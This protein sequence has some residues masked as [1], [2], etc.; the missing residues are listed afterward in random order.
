MPRCR[1]NSRDIRLSFLVDRVTNRTKCNIDRCPQE[2]R[3]IKVKTSTLKRH[4]LSKHAAKA[5]QLDLLPDNENNENGESDENSCEVKRFR[6]QVNPNRIKNAALKLVTVHGLPLSLF[7]YEGF[8]ELTEELFSKINFKI[9][10]RNCHNLLALAAHQIR[11]KIVLE[12][13]NKM[14]SLKI[15]ITTRHGKHILGIILQFHS[16]EKIVSRNIG[17]IELFVRH[18]GKNISA[19]IVK[20]LDSFGCS[21]NQIY[22]IAIDN[23]RN[24]VTTVEFIRA[25]QTVS[26]IPEVETVEHNDHAEFQFERELKNEL[27]GIKHKRLVRKRRLQPDF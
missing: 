6:M 3:G 25:A 8:R 4:I 13:A 23:G 10:R 5:A 12:I 20:V 18:S 26:T 19:E 9:N 1:G 24:M 2:F 21:M 22:S 17:M 7:N 16:E 14:V 15:D 11:Q 27:E